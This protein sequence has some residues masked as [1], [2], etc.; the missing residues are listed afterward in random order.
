[1]SIQDK[2]NS[3]QSRM[4]SK[5]ILRL[6]NEQLQLKVCDFW[7]R[8]LNGLMG[9]IFPPDRWYG[10]CCYVNKESDDNEE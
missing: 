8:T 3:A 9:R 2:L 7:N 5:P 6:A 1:M 10:Q 4:F